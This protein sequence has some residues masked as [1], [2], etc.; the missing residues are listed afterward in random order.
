MKK[1][2]LLG[3]FSLVFFM[4]ASFAAA[5]PVWDAANFTAAI[6]AAENSTINA[7]YNSTAADNGALAF[8]MLGE[9]A[10]A[11][12]TSLG[13]RS[14][15]FSWTPSFTQAGSY[16][17]N[18]T[19]SD[20]NSSD[21][22]TVTITISDLANPLSAD[23]SM[24]VIPAQSVNEGKQLIFNITASAPD[25]GA[26]NSFSKN[27]TFGTLTPVSNTAATFA[28]TPTFSDAGV[29]DINFS[30]QD[31]DSRNSKVARIT[32]VNVP[33]EISSTSTLSLGGSSQ[34]RSNPR[35]DDVADRE[36]NVSGT[37]TITNTGSET[38]TNLSLSGVSTKLGLSSTDLL[39]SASFGST[40]LAIGQ[41]TTATVTARVPEK[42]DAVD[43]NLNPASFSVASLT[44]SANS[45]T[46]GPVTAAADLKMQAENKLD[47]QDIDVAFGTKTESVDN[48]DSVDGLK[49]GNQVTMRVK[50]ENR[51]SSKEDLEIEDI[52][53]VVESDDLDLD[54]DE[55]F[56]TLGPREE[57]TASI[58][59][60]ID[61]DAED[62][63]NDVE[64][65]I[66]GRDE[67]G[68]RHGEKWTIQLEVER[69]S[70]EVAIDEFT[71]VPSTLG[72]QDEAQL[73]V[74]IRNVGRSDEDEVILRIESPE[75]KYG[76]VID[77]LELDEDDDSTHRFVI[78][79]KNL[80]KGTYRI[81]IETYYESDHLSNRDVAL[82][83][84]EGCSTEGTAPVTPPV[85]TE[86]ED[87]GIEVVPRTEEP[88]VSGEPE[89]EEKKVSFF[90]KPEYVALLVAANVAVLVGAVW[91][92]SQLFAKP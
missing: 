15:R 19:A 23:P 76:S 3:I 87:S 51:F 62:Q 13:G 27:V 85:Q 72:C 71:L 31:G 82:L 57:D 26:T 10:G 28:W 37:V 55:D 12:L 16:L 22:K 35:A 91:L 64:I 73:S 63:D 61:E 18:L 58:S 88:P 53:L 80:S 42:L 24:A 56:G 65:R 4:L 32:V 69:K 92:F 84:A 39:V 81:T 6:A 89:Q 38:L 11:V 45:Q 20:A 33:A 29:F 30:V 60:E 48:G 59:F 7:D 2:A 83:R 75:L 34:K 46:G 14:V 41:T 52:E 66:E 21:R 68:A 70:H 77:D 1:S 78:P 67:N 17:V 49:P 74:T 54:E 47:L 43:S 36:V 50:A 40:S 86:P 5:S 44:F 79:T 90:E 9:P 25:F 8:S